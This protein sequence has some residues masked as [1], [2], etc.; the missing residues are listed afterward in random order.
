M[1]EENETEATPV[2]TEEEIRKAKHLA[3]VAKNI[4]NALAEVDW[5]EDELKTAGLAL[6]NKRSMKDLSKGSKKDQAFFKDVVIPK[7]KAIALIFD[8]HMTADIQ[9]KLEAEAKTETAPATT[10]PVVA[11]IANGANGTA[12][13]AEIVS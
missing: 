7:F 1:S 6:Y 9:K 3:I 12:T 11:P 10:A 5:K 13:P 2:P 8:V 4:W